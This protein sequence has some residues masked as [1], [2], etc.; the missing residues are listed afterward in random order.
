MFCLAT[1]AKRS[2]ANM[3]KMVLYIYVLLTLLSTCLFVSF[4][5]LQLYKQHCFV[6]FVEMCSAQ[7]SMKR[8]TLW[9]HHVNPQHIFV[10]VLMTLSHDAKCT[11]HKP[12][13]GKYAN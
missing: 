5:H 2:L 12:T 7:M 9:L 13:Q 4:F 11:Q 8:F 1:G 10:F 6:C 3:D